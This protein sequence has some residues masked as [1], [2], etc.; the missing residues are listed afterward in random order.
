MPVSFVSGVTARTSWIAPDGSYPLR[1]P[2]PGKG[3]HD[4][5]LAWQQRKKQH[6]PFL[7]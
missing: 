1:A 5:P 6:A 4:L 7:G 3:A 2:P